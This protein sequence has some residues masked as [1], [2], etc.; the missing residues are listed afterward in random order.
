VKVSYT[1]QQS[2]HVE[3]EMELDHD[4][5]RAVKAAG[6]TAERQQILDPLIAAHALDEPNPMRGSHLSSTTF[7]IS[8]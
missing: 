8:A 7:V 4:V 1:Y 6:S 5:E 2:T 3:S